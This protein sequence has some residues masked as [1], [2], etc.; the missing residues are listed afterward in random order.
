[1]R[2]CPL[3]LNLGEEVGLVIFHELMHIT[4]GVYDHAN[5]ELAYGKDGMVKLAE[6]DPV[7][8]RLNA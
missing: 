5:T 4:S 7:G 1:M 2:M 3:S 6:E 8:A